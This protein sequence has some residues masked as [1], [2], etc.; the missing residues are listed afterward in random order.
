[1]YLF[2]VT[3]DS[4]CGDIKSFAIPSTIVSFA[5]PSTIVS[6]VYG[7]VL[8]ETCWVTPGRGVLQ[9]CRWRAGFILRSMVMGMV[10]F[11]YWDRRRFPY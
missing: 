10:I 11:G 2:L 3:G 6:G 9:T 7:V 4:P 8:D 5:I 1:M